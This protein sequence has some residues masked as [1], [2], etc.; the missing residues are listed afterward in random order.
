MNPITHLLVS[1]VIADSSEFD[2]KERTAVTLSGV[3]PDIDSFGIIAEQLTKGSE[4]PLLW[5]SDYH[6]VLGHNI[7]FGLLVV[8]VVFIVSKKKWKTMGFALFCFHLHLLCDVVGAKGPDGYQWPIPYLLPFSNAI[9]IV[10]KYQW[11]INAWPNFVITI[12]ALMITF[13]YAWKH[14]YSI[15]VNISQKADRVFVRTVKNRFEY[16]FKSNV[17]NTNIKS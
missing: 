12:A 11:Q 7:G 10:W 8:L 4:R 9:Q 15:L 3:I 13:Y 17:E 1:W 5:W 2:N 6:H 16:Y 14:G